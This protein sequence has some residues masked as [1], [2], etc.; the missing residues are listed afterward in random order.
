MGQRPQR[1]ARLAGRRRRLG[2][3][4]ELRFARAVQAA[5]PRRLGLARQRRG[6]PVVHGLAPPAAHADR[7]DVPRG[8]DGFVRPPRAL[9]AR[10]ALEQGAG[11][12]DLP[13][14][15]A[16]ASAAALGDAG[17]VLPF[18]GGQV[19]SVFQGHGTPSSGCWAIGSVL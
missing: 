1:P 7:R 18:G 11:A 14:G 10:V 3:L 4:Q 17:Q 6:R 15:R 12:H 16:P 9:R 13:Q 8:R 2:Q 5:G 19:Q